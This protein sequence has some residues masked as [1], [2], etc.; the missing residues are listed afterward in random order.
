M[1]IATLNLWGAHAPL[2]RRLAA[3]AHGLRALELDALLV[4]EVRAG[5]DV[6]NTADQL[7][8]LL[9]GDWRAAY[10]AAARGDAGAFGPGSAA[11]EEG[12]AILAPG[13][14][15]DVRA[16]R[17]PAGRQGAER[18][19]L[20]ARVGAIWAHT[21]HLNWRLGDGL[22]REAQVV[23]A[24]EAARACGDGVHVLG[25]D[26]NAAPDCDEIR[27]L[28]G[29]HTLAG[30]REVWQDAF[31][32]ARP[33][34]RGDT[35]ARRNP[36]TDELAHLERD[37]RIDYLFISPEQRGGRGRVVDARVILDAPDPDGVWASDHF[38]VLAEITA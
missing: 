10:V 22:A 2:E 1:R 6:A 3:A 27:F 4:Q 16:V 35:F 32:R 37:R 33:G 7:A 11:G 23:A 24:S 26:F 18:L 36:M 13:P 8:A 25:G 9:G 29:R 31:A 12:L 34:E 30:R 5:S 38:G 14:I 20:S 15:A 17:L 19:L 28:L 21:T